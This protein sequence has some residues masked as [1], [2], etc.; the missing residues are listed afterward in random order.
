MGFKMKY[1]KLFENSTIDEFILEDFKKW[2][3]EIY[4]DFDSMINSNLV[5]NVTTGKHQIAM[6]LFTDAYMEHLQ[7]KI[8]PTIIRGIIESI[9]DMCE[10]EPSYYIKYKELLDK[11]GIKNEG[12]NR[13]EKTGLWDMKGDVE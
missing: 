2:F 3:S 9:K 6:H 12:I 4:D 10:K 11:L 5:F 13:G 8:Q 7:S 1:L